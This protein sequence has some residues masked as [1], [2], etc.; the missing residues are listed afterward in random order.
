M[1]S[2]LHSLHILYI[3]TGKQCKKNTKIKALHNDLTVEDT[4]R[5]CF[6]EKKGIHKCVQV[7]SSAPY[8]VARQEGNANING[9]LA[10][11]LFLFLPVI[12]VILS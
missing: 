12:S 1:R 3:P 10:P 7:I 2:E 9:Q 11:Q 5:R 6:S 4:T 8:W